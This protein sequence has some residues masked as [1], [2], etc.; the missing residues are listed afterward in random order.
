M[1]TFRLSRP[2]K[3]LGAGLAAEIASELRLPGVEIEEVEYPME[4]PV[5]RRAM[6]GGP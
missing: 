2:L 5:R 3:E 1:L 6:S 4:E